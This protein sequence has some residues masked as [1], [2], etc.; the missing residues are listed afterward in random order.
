MSPNPVRPVNPFRVGEIVTGD[1]YCAR[2]DAE[3]ALASLLRSKQRV[4]LQDERRTGKTS[5]TCEVA[6]KHFGNR[7]VRIAL[8]PSSE[9]LE[10]VN[11]L[12]T[13]WGNFVRFTSKNWMDRLVRQGLNFSVDLKIL[14]VTANP[15]RP[16][17]GI[18]K[19]FSLVDDE[20]KKPILFFDEFQFAA[21]MPEKE[22]TK[23][24]WALRDA[25]QLRADV[26]VVFAGSDRNRLADIF[27]HARNPFY[28]T[29]HVLD[30][31]PVDLGRMKAFVSERF[32]RGG[33]SLS[34]EGWTAIVEFT[35]GVPGYIQ[36]LCLAVWEV[37]GGRKIDA[38]AV[39]D[40]VSRVLRQFDNFRE[41]VNLTPLQLRFGHGVAALEPESVTNAA[42]LE[43][44]QIKS[45]SSALRP[46]KLFEEDLNVIEKRDGQYRFYNPFMREWFRRQL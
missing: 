6:R 10:I 25:L 45:S 38:A 37:A 31:P 16:T 30:L 36:E 5:L 3:R 9:S 40:G 8:S 18:S 17:D 39:E 28:N 29:V 15:A 19:F 35:R 13:G 12:L 42:F 24:F 44:T 14:K 41:L 1:A 32:T 11:A 23:F 26:P 20:K 43:F 4:L 22:S 34:D 33:L 2:P 7:I 46:R 27:F 21:E